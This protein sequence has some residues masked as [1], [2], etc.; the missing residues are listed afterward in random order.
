MKFKLF[1]FLTIVSS[2]TISS[3]SPKLDYSDK[4]NWCS[5]SEKEVI[6]LKEE[7]NKKYASKEN[8][9]DIN[10]ACILKYYGTYEANKSFYLIRDLGNY[11]SHDE[12][13]NYTNVFYDLPWYIESSSYFYMF[14]NNNLYEMFYAYEHNMLIRK[15]LESVNDIVVE[16]NPF[17][18]DMY[19][20]F[21]D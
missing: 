17:L 7:F 5:L 9:K 6:T 12:H 19:P 10:N 18:K 8:N 21:I 15:T 1:I 2:F 11:Y 3:C 16:D 14:Y 4:D 13:T 20:Q